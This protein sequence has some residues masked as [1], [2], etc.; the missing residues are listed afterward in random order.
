MVEVEKIHVVVDPLGRMD[1]INTA[2]MLMNTPKTLANWQT[3]GI[4]PR[5]FKVGGKTFY[6]AEEVAK[7]GRGE[8]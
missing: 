8:A 1:R 5:A 3:K 7:F 4:G 6:W 2:K